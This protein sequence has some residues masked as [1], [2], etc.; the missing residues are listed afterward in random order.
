MP[1]DHPIDAVSLARQPKRKQQ[2]AGQEVHG[3]ISPS[4]SGSS[5]ACALEPPGLGV[6]A[7]IENARIAQLLVAAF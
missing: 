7:H 5:P 6:E 3:R 4:W 2:I 1:C